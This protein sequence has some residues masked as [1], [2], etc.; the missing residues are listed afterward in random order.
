MSDQNGEKFDEAG[1][2]EMTIGTNGFE[3]RLA[4]LAAKYFASTKKSAEEHIARAEVIVQAEEE[5]GKKYLNGFYDTI[6]VKSGSSTLKKLRKV[7][8]E[9]QRFKPYLDRCPDCWTTIYNLAVVPK[10]KFLMLATQMVFSLAQLLGKNC[11]RTASS[12]S[13]S[14]RRLFD[15]A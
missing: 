8:E 6:G 1:P 10:E 2:G 12:R 15:H 4:E 13:R 7:G 9:A 14:S 5:F 11:A 3:A